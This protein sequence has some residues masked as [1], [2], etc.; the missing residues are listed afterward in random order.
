M[1]PIEEKSDFSFDFDNYRS[2]LAKG[3]E[4][5]LQSSVGKLFFYLTLGV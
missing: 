5:N 3:A 1:L 2:M 4:L